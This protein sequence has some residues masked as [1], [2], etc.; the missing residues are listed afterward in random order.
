MEQGDPVAEMGGQEAQKLGSQGNFRD[1]KHGAFARNQA[2]FDQFQVDR[3]LAGAGDA[4]KQ[5]HAGFGFI[6]L[7]PE[8]VKGGLLLGVEGQRCI[9]LCRDDLAAA[10][11]RAGA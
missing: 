2:V 4:V 5:R 10:E 8:S 11:H 6:R 3:G 9:Q 1:E 7:L